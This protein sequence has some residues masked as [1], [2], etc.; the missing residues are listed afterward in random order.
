VCQSL[1]AVP[2]V[3]DALNLPWD[4]AACIEPLDQMWADII[5]EAQDAGATRALPD[6]M[7]GRTRTKLSFHERV[8]QTLP[9]PRSWSG[10]WEERP[11]WGSIG[12]FQPALKKKVLTKL[13]CEPEATQH[14]GK[15]GAD[16]TR[17]LT[18]RKA[19]SSRSL[20]QTVAGHI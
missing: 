3:H 17:D 14:R 1:P 16:G 6:V 4:A 5:G 2:F 20:F 11:N 18:G 8:C 13:G 15:P 9:P 10:R 12:F 19:T 7:A